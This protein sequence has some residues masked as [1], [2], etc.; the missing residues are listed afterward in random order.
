M[1]GWPSTTFTVPG[2]HVNHVPGP[3]ITRPVGLRKPIS[4]AGLGCVPASGSGR[5]RRGARGALERPPH[6]PH[7]GGPSGPLLAG[8]AVVPAPRPPTCL[9]SR[10]PQCPCSP[11]FTF[12]LGVDG[13]QPHPLCVRQ[14][15][16]SP[17]AHCLQPLLRSGTS[18][19][20]AAAVRS[21]P[22]PAPPG[23]PLRL[24]PPLPPWALVRPVSRAGHVPCQCSG[25]SPEACSLPQCLWELASYPPSWT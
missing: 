8:W 3:E 19:C 11:G 21:A 14:H 2:R 15:P 23:P 16:T 13:V 5:L 6:R 1:V 4:P 10:P 12:H 7:A 24:R 17:A 9:P 20:G 22:R 18:C 25:P